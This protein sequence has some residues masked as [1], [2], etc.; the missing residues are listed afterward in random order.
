MLIA[1]IYAYTNLNLVYKPDFTDKVDDPIAT[2][3]RHAQ[4]EL[5]TV[6]ATNKARRAK[7]TAIARDHLAYQ[8]YLELRDSIDKNISTLFGKLQKKDGPKI[9]RK[10]K[11][12]VG[13]AAA[14]HAA[15]VAAQA[16]AQSSAGNAD[17]SG[18]SSVAGTA[19]GGSTGGAEAHLPLPAALGLGPDD[20]NR[21]VVNEQLNHL[22]E[23]RRQWVNTVGKFFD[24]RQRHDPGR[25]FGLPTQSVFKD[26]QDE[27]RQNLEGIE[28]GVTVEEERRR[29]S[30]ANAEAAATSAA[31]MEGEMVN[32]EKDR[33]DE[34]DVG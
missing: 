27:I 26:M 23:T 1:R 24:D 25:N 11:K 8:E 7:L 30:K 16:Q 6:L 14:A 33:E 29:Q 12:I 20:E 19:N 4:S 18:S 13:A 15:A 34:M 32:M 2:A 9:G 28:M 31:I 17:G 10:K 3:L 5:R 21:L 22:V